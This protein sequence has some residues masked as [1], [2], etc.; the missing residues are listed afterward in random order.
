MHWDYIVSTDDMTEYRIRSDPGE[1]Y[2]LF[3]WKKENCFLWAT[4]SVYGFH[5][6]GLFLFPT[7]CYLKMTAQFF[8]R[9]LLVRLYCFVRIFNFNSQSYLI[10]IKCFFNAPSS[11]TLQIVLDLSNFSCTFPTFAIKTDKIVE[12]CIKRR[13]SH[14][15]PT[16]IIPATFWKQF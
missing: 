1:T 7:L 16:I 6:F 10:L 3:L 4:F 5:C 14:Y 15:I 13:F 12:I 2:F 8:K 9:Q 11:K